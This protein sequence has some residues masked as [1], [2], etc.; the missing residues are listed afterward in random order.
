VVRVAFGDADAHGHRDGAPSAGCRTP[1]ARLLAA[2]DL[3]PLLAAQVEGALGDRL[4]QLFQVGPGLVHVL[5]REQHGEL[6]A[7]VAVGF[8]AATHRA[9][10][11]GDQLE[12]LVT[13]V[14]AV[15]VVARR[16]GSPV[17]SSRKAMRWESRTMAT[18]TSKPAAVA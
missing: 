15:A 16:P 6:L 14:V 12:H 9:H 1:L 18:S 4:A 11:R 8:P 7:A 10:P 5:A 17:N 3:R 13:D 2:F